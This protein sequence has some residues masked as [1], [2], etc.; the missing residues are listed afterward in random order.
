MGILSE[1]RILILK[2][3]KLEIRNLYSLNSILLYVFSSVFVSYLAFEKIIQPQTW[4]ALFWIILLFAAVNAISTSF[5]S[6]GSKKFYYYYYVLSPRSII[7]SKLMYNSIM[8]L[9]VA[10]LTFVLYSM[11]FGSIINNLPL[12]LLILLF[13]SFGLS[14][15]LTMVSAIASR[16]GNNFALM[17]ILSFPVI[18][19]MLI[20][21]IRLSSMTIGIIDLNDFVKMMIA[22]VVLDF[23]VVAMAVVLFPFLWKE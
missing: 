22:L 11:V 8:L 7:L 14:G 6:E 1:I 12:F 20:V 18:L 4:N 13:G 23:I 16:A 15:I 10:V 3:F 21:L 9:V 19:P 17:S 2:D 5:T